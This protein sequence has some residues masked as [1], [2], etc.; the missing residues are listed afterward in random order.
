MR[1]LHCNQSAA[2]GVHASKLFADIE[3]HKQN[4]SDEDASIEQQ[5]DNPLTVE[6]IRSG[7][8]SLGYHP[9]TLRHTY[10]SLTLRVSE[11]VCRSCRTVSYRAPYLKLY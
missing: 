9:Q 2:R 1:S 10:T 6:L 11:A 4:N 5:Q 7:L 8:G 3:Q